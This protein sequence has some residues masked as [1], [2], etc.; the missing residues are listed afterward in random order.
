MYCYVGVKLKRKWICKAQGVEL[1]IF[2]SF[3]YFT[4][5]RI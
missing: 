5:N 1:Y 2:E 3:F 4:W